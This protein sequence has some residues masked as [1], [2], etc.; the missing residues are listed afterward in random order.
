VCREDPTLTVV[1]RHTKVNKMLKG[2]CSS[3]R[4]GYRNKSIAS[5]R[6]FY[7]VK[8]LGPVILFLAP[9]IKLS[10]VLDLVRNT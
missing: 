5:A 4:G 3:L 2:G 6:L 9:A 10:S 8:Y 1:Q 7:L